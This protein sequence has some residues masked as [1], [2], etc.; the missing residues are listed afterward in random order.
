MFKYSSAAHD[1]VEVSKAGYDSCSASSPIA[2]YQTGNDT[3]QLPTGSVTRYFICGV[4]GHCAA[5]MK[6]AVTVQPADDSCRNRR[7]RQRRS[8][9]PLS[10]GRRLC[11]SESDVPSSGS[12]SAS[13]SSVL[14][15]MVLLTTLG[16]IL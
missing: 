9:G 2:T 4:P 3:V 15:V 7:P 5:G 16:L 12:S 1:V 14:V 8:T 13:V 6:L 10:G 11:P